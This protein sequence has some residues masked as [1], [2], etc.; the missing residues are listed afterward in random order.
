MLPDTQLHVL[1]VHEPVAEPAILLRPLRS[2]CMR[3]RTSELLRAALQNF[4]FQCTPAHTVGADEYQ[5]F[6]AERREFDNFLVEAKLGTVKL[7]I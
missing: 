6:S 3:Y 7:S 2:R 1:P 4:I 5:G